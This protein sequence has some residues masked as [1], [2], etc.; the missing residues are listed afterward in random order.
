MGILRMIYK[1]KCKNCSL[2][3]ITIERDI[4]AEE[5]IDELELQRSGTLEESKK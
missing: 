3:G 4:E 5:K 2:C 1:S